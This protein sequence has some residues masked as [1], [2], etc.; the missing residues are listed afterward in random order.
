MLLLTI[1]WLS[2]SSECTCRYGNVA[3][4]TT[5]RH[6]FV[7]GAAQWSSIPTGTRSYTTD[8]IPAAL[9]LAVHCANTHSQLYVLERFFIP[10]MNYES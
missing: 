2:S 4:G 3:V 6:F 8:H 7:L 5:R 9:L 1:V 10:A